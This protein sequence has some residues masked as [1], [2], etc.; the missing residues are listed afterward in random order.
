MIEPAMALNDELRVHAVLNRAPTHRTSADTQRA[1]AALR[2]LE[3]IHLSD[4][5]IRERSSLRRCV[6]SGQLI[7]E[8]K[9]P[10]HKAL[11]EMSAAHELIFGAVA[12]V[13]AQGAA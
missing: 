6:P 4:V 8:W 2:A 3:I 9:P 10:D 7:D 1:V 13:S 11:T 5:I 12:S